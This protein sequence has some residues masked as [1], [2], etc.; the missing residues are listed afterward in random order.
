M[1]CVRRHL[2]TVYGILALV[3]LLL[4]IVIVILFSLN[5]PAGKFNY[6]WE[7]FT[8]HYWKNPFGVPGPVGRDG[9]EPQGGAAL[10][11]VVATML[12]T[13]IALALVRYR[14]RGRGAT[15]FAHL[16]ADGGRRRSCSAPRC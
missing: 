13:L 5:D 12:G 6:T 10:A 9:D 7:G 8:L 16:P 2:L 1:A 14:F 15:N 4:P 3:Y 11:T